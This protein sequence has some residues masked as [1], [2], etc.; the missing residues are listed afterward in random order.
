MTVSRENVLVF[1][2]AFI[3]DIVLMLPMLQVLRQH[4]P[5]ASITVVV[6]PA[7]ADL[8]AQHP[9]VSRVI[10]YDKRGAHRGMGGMRALWRQLRLERFT[11]AIVPHRSLRSALIARMAH[12][13]RRIGFSTS[14]GARLFTNR[15]R[16]R[17]DAHEIDRDLSLLQPLIG[18]MPE[19]CLP[20]V[21][22]T[23]RDNE[24]AEHLL[25]EVLAH[26]PTA[27]Q[28]P[29]VALAPGSVWATKRWPARSYAA[30]AESLVSE[31]LTVVLVGGGRDRDLCDEIKRTL[32]GRL[33]VIDAVGKLTLTGT[34]ALLTRCRVLVSN[35]SAPAHIA[36]GVGTPVIGLFGPTV[37]AIG[38][39]PVGPR[40]QVLQVLDL[41]CRPC[42]I[43]GGNECPIGSFECMQGISVQRVKAAVQQIL[44]DQQAE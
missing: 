10:A 8:V 28:T 34:A 43:H 27:K 37:P 41:E 23:D 1:H 31:D 3:G 11:T 4:F 25:A 38:F 12:I 24:A 5:E 15:V 44:S 42:N 2:T 32:E 22:I 13:P 39:A 30:L 18:T 16:Y 21:N 7:V 33:S 14:S 36:M 20:V 6:I 35:D 26:R 40:D 29:I 9:A 19:R 17:P